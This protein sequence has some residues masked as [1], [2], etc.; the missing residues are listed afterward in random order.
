MEDEEEIKDPSSF[1]NMLKTTL[2][3]I[4]RIPMMVLDPH[5]KD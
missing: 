5:R 2:Y 1:W 3:W 4:V